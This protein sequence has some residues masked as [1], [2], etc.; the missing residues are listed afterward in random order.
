MSHRYKQIKWE[1]ESLLV[2]RFAYA[3]VIGIITKLSLDWSS[4]FVL[5][6]VYSVLESVVFF[7]LIKRTEVFNAENEY[8]EKSLT[9]HQGM[10]IYFQSSRYASSYAAI[11]FC[12]SFSLISFFGALSKWILEIFLG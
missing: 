11:G 3:S 4:F 2:V 10:R 7:I 8:E 12:L 1:M 6:A 5:V 9:G